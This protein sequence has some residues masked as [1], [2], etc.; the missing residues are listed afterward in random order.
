VVFAQPSLAGLTTC[1]LADLACEPVAFELPADNLYHWRLG[2]RSLFVRA[3][4][5]SAGAFSR[6]DF[7]TRKLGPGVSLT[8]SGA[9]TSIAVSP[10]ES[11][12]LVVARGRP[13]DRSHD[14]Q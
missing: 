2:P 6:Y 3:R 11:E 14:R 13:G 1:R 4:E 7:A 5:A 8:P 10:D 12:L 9:G